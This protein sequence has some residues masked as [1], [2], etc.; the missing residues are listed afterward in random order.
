MDG[1]LGDIPVIPEPNFNKP[2]LEV[3]ETNIERG[4]RNKRSHI[5][6]VIK[7]RSYRE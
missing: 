4:L 3:M 5:V 1:I 2:L 7:H 6:V